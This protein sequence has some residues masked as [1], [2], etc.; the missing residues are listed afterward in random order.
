MK[1]RQ[2]EK[3]KMNE[4]VRN[5]VSWVQKRDPRWQEY[6]RKRKEEQEIKEETRRK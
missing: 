5:L 6:Q 4:A 1:E 2:K 3:R